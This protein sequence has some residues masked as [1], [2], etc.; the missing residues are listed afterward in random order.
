ML[1]LQD[2]G[3]GLGT[4]DSL[5]SG[6][7]YEANSRRCLPL[8]PETMTTAITT[9]WVAT[10]LFVRYWCWQIS[11][12]CLKNPTVCV[13]ARLTATHPEARQKK[14]KHI[15][16]DYKIFSKIVPAK[17]YPEPKNLVLHI[18]PSSPTSSDIYL[19]AVCQQCGINSSKK[20][21]CTKLRFTGA[22][23]EKR[24]TTKKERES[25][26]FNFDGDSLTNVRPDVGY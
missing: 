8:W 22:E 24:Q 19:A 18:P 20:A 1:C 6:G 7:K 2:Q 21:R 17:C 10:V 4:G 9:T 5:S 15:L 13:C 25:W 23:K 14:A 16:W 26:L 12:A 3:K 11:F